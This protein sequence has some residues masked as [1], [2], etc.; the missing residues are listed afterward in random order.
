MKTRINQ[1]TRP[2]TLIILVLLTGTCMKEIRTGFKADFD[3]I[4]DRTWI[5]RE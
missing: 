5:G 3:N 1:I 2:L 4:N